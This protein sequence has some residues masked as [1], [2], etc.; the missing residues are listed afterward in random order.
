MAQI[1]KPIAYRVDIIEYESG[2]VCN[3]DEVT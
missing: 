1:N 2:W 3:V